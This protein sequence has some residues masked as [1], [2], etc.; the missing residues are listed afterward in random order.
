MILIISFSLISACI[1]ILLHEYWVLH[2]KIKKLN[3]KISSLE[4]KLKHT[5]KAH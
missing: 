3:R 5:D 2:E 4:S 1:C